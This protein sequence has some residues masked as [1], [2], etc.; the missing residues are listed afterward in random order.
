MKLLHAEGDIK[1][2]GG[3]IVVRYSF[4]SANPRFVAYCVGLVTA[5]AI[6][7]TGQIPSTLERDKFLSFVGR[8]AGEVEKGLAAQQNPPDKAGKN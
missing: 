4:D 2:P 5:A 3:K 8:I 1:A 6:I 7:Q